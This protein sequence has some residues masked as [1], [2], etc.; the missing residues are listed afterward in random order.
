MM[1]PSITCCQKTET[2][3]R[4]NPFRSNP[5]IIAPMN[6]P[7]AVPRPPK[8]LA[9]PMITAAI[10]SSSAPVPAVG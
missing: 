2:F 8:K 6:T 3:I 4:F 1:N 9:P 5:M 7:P 10:A